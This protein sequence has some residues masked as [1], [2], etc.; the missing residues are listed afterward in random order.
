MLQVALVLHIRQLGRV[1]VP[2]LSL[3]LL[4]EA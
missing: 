2:V 3:L 4:H 1:P